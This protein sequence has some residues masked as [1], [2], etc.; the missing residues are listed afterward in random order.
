MNS[1]TLG[2]LSLVVGFSVMA[3][4]SET[5]LMRCHTKDQYFFVEII[6]RKK[7]KKTAAGLFARVSN[8]VGFIVSTC[9]VDDLS[10]SASRSIKL[11]DS[12]YNG[13]LFKLESSQPGSNDLVLNAIVTSPYLG[14]VRIVRPAV[15]ETV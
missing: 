15:C 5:L 13:Q 10:L 6:E 11:V 4:A 7:D 8:R 9:S 12:V 2:V 14:N 1:R 3:L